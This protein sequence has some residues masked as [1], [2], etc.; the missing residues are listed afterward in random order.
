MWPVN[1]K[2]GHHKGEAREGTLDK[3]VLGPCPG[4][5]SL[6]VVSNLSGN[7]MNLGHGL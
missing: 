3:K 1:A 6:S 4:R 5:S 7:R 2:I